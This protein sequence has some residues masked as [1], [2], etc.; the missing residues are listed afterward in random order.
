MLKTNFLIE[1]KSIRNLEKSSQTALE[2][3]TQEVLTA[4]IVVKGEV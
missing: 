3:F 1:D 2:G 4:N